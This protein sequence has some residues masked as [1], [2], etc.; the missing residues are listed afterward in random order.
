MHACAASFATAQPR[1]PVVHAF[2]ASGAPPPLPFPQVR[3]DPKLIAR[4]KKAERKATAS[5]LLEPMHQKKQQQQGAQAQQQGAPAA[6]GAVSGA[7]GPAAEPQL[8]D[9]GSVA[10]GGGGGAGGSMWGWGGPKPK[11]AEEYEAWRCGRALE[12]L[13]PWKANQS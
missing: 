12:T 4:A 7:G 11:T 6:S 10:G 1:L 2:A 3:I 13:Q 5:R 9:G 8:E